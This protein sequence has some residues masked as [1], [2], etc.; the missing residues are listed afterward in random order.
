MRMLTIEVSG[1]VPTVGRS[2]MAAPLSSRHFRWCMYVFAL[3]AFLGGCSSDTT[4]PVTVLD[5]IAITDLYIE[6]TAIR[7]GGALVVQAVPDP[8][9]AA[10]IQATD[11]TSVQIRSSKGDA[12]TLE[13]RP[14]VC[15]LNDGSKYLC[16]TFY[17]AM[18]AGHH[19]AEVASHLQQV[20]GVFSRVL[21]GGEHA[22]IRILQGD[23]QS[24]MSQAALWPG[25]RLVE[26]SGI[27]CI[28]NVTGCGDGLEGAL[29]IAFGDQETGDGLL[30]V[31]PGDTLTIKYGQPDGNSL[32][33]SIVI[34]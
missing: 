15:R 5:T 27:G 11:R 19:V 14:R 25:V 29:A 32:E 24:A 18:T 23:L 2:T 6:P 28:A 20:H 30:R 31:E 13:L 7:E 12:D 22:S 8:K 21:G 1:R 26:L 33:R 16:D 34:R 9:L 10:P 17:I 3:A 4:E